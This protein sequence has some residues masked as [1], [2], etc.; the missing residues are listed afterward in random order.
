MTIQRIDFLDLPLDTGA[1]AE[2]LPRLMREK[3]K[4]RLVTFVNPAAWALAR[5][6][7]GYVT[8]LHAMS[9]IVPDGEG[10]ARACRWLTSY[11]CMRLS[12][13]MTSLA[14]IFFKTLV[15]DNGSLMLIG[16]N[17]GVDEAMHE[18]LHFNYPKLNIV[19]TTHGYDDFAPKISRIIE[20]APD[21]VLVGVGSPRQEEFLVAL[22]DAGYKGFAVTCGGFFDQYLKA[23]YY[24]PQWVDYWNLRFAWRLYKEPQRL[25][26]RYLI[27]YQI[28]I[29]RVLKALAQ[30]I[31]PIGKK[32]ADTR[33]AP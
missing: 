2:D 12:F 16:G 7:P 4:T 33:T 3:G 19:G 28:F 21:A 22:C 20:A 29:W 23:E 24:Y 32:N 8:A 15:E 17:P 26:R 13:D 27:D 14:D 9:L 31:V 18:K 6:N 30:K 11:E 25:W 1:K 5:R 10:V